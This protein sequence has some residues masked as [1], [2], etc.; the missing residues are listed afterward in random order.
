MLTLTFTQ[1]FNGI[2]T[3]DGVFGAVGITDATGDSAVQ[4]VSPGDVAMLNIPVQPRVDSYVKR[5][6]CWT[7]TANLQN[8]NRIR[9]SAA[10]RGRA[11]KER[12]I[13]GLLFHFRNSERVSVVGQWLSEVDSMDIDD[14]DRLSHV[15]VYYTQKAGRGVSLRR[16]NGMVTG[17]VMSTAK[18]ARKSVMCGVCEEML[19]S[20]YY[21]NH[22][23]EM[24]SSATVYA[25]VTFLEPR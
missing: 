3:F 14:G 22:L 13:S 5:E 20:D 21:A 17:M 11:R 10:L 23:E 8:V 24:V 9:F 6:G 4:G 19:F 25:V 7:S 1:S 12:H 16:N 15:R 18:G 2:E